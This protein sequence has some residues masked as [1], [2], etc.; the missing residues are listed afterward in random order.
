MGKGKE[1]GGAPDVLRR[2]NSWWFP[3]W[4]KEGDVRVQ[5]GRQSCHWVDSMGDM[6]TLEGRRSG[7]R[8]GS[9]LGGQLRMSG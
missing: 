2:K 9:G 7:L 5:S 6:T 8:V 4:R 3:G 1:R